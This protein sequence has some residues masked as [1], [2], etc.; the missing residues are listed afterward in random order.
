MKKIAIYT[1]L[2]VLIISQISCISESIRVSGEVSTISYAFSDYDALEISN[3]FNAFIKFSDTEEKIEVEANDNL[4]QHIIIKMINGK[5]SIKLKNLINV[6]G[7]EVL[8]LYI[9]TRKI[10]DFKASGDSNITLE[11]ELISP[12]IN[13]E[14]TGDSNFAGAITTSNLK[15]LARGDSKVDVYGNADDLNAILQ[16]DSKLDDYDLLVKDLKIKLSGDST[17]HLSVSESI[18]VDASG[19]S[20]LYYKGEATIIF[21]RLT[22]GS[23]IIKK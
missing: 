13:I 17:A 1:L 19:D 2:L 21:E 7:K 20:Y 10:I 11:N 23:R 22:G 3:D 18:D 4:H 8:N 14:V 16:G 15:I 9:T 5:L 6:R 12:N